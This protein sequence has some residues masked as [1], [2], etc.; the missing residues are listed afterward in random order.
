[1]ESRLQDPASA[2]DADEYAEADYVLKT[3]DDQTGDDVYYYFQES[4]SQPVLLGIGGAD[5]PPGFTDPMSSAAGPG[6][7]QFPDFYPLTFGKTLAPINILI[8]VEFLGLQMIG[9]YD[10]SGEVDAWGQ[11]SVPAGTFDALRVNIHGEGV[12]TIGIEDE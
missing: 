12:L 6:S 11:V 7:Q 9:A 3:S 4:D 2:P 5:L 1:M 10:M 8:D